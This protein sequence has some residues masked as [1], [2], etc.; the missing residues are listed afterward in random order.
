M[1]SVR[2]R[3]GS[4]R[5]SVFTPVGTALAAVRS[6]IYNKLGQGR[7]LSLR[8]LMFVSGGRFAPAVSL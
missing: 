4:A 2:G 5:N 6:E 3:L 7:A 8:Y 1:L